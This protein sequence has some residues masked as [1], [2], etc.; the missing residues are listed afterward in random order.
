M[1]VFL[2]GGTGFIGQ[3][4]TQ[5]LLDLGWAVRVLVRH[6]ESPQ[7]ARLTA[8]GAQ[9][10]QGDILDPESIK[11]GM[12][13]ANL[14]VHNAGMYE[15]G[16]DA[17]GRK[18][19]ADIN[20]RG[21]ENVLLAAKA[22]GI[23]RTVYVS[24]AAYWGET[25][26]EVWDETAVRK[27]PSGNF[28]EDTKTRAHDFALAQ[29]RNGQ[30]LIIVCP[31]QV[32]G[33]ND[34]SVFGYFIRMYLNRIMPPFGWAPEAVNTYTYVDDMANGI[35]LAAQKGRVGETYIIAGEIMTKRTLLNIWTQKPGAAQSWIYL[36]VWLAKIM[37]APMAP[38]LRWLKLPAFISSETIN[39]DVNRRFS[40]AKAQ[41][42][43]GW[44][45]RSGE[46][47]WLDTLTK[48]QALLEKRK[49]Q[50]L[51]ERLKPLEE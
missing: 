21:T 19:M 6:P 11:A 28:Y 4:L 48:E 15:L 27:V 18:R 2:T 23:P 29:I 39:G 43:L 36:P 17:A 8:L 1:K 16:V 26:D 20:E 37:F 13:G 31:G 35:A 47:I 46:Q 3:P 10:V 45:F 40:S 9:C 51:L 12:E 33:P 49:G 41:Q 22:L 30:P 34:H 25:G 5:A 38:L 44:T 50:T 24:T 7:A 42:E 14:V 32:I